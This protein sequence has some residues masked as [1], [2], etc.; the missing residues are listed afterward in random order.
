MAPQEDYYQKFMRS[1]ILVKKMPHL[2]RYN[3]CR[4]NYRGLSKTT[5]WSQE[6]E[7]DLQIT[8]ERIDPY[9]GTHTVTYE[10][11]IDKITLELRQP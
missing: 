1:I 9:Y 6:N 3:H 7:P 5:N 8:D 10:S 4:R 11:T 2:E